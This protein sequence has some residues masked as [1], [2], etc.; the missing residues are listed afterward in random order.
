MALSEQLQPQ[1]RSILEQTLAIGA[2][3]DGQLEADVNQ[4]IGAWEMG[5]VF[6][7]F[8]ISG[9]LAIA[10]TWAKPLDPSRD[11]DEEETA[12]GQQVRTKLDL[13][14]AKLAVLE[15]AVTSSLT[16]QGT[17]P[18]KGAGVVQ[19]DQLGAQLAVAGQSSALA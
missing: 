2:S 16:L 13:V 10:F 9:L 8:G 18:G 11:A 17:L 7:V 1:Y 6:V 15:G 12:G 14:L 5:G 4:K 3:C 19:F